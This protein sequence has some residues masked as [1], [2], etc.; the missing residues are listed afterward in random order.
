MITNFEEL[1]AD[2]SEDELI[3]KDEVKDHLLKVLVPGVIVKQKDIAEILNLRM[4]QQ[5]GQDGIMITP[6]RLRKFFNYFRTNGSLP[7]VATSQGCYISFSKEEIQKQIISLEER[8]RQILRA[9]EGMKK[10]LI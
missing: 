7:L 1:T 3:F 8:A 9:A 5:H 4:F 2:L 6:T 10:F